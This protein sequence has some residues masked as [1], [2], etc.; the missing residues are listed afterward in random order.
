MLGSGCFL[1]LHARSQPKLFL[2]ATSSSV[3]KICRVDKAYGSALGNEEIF[4]LCDK[5]QKGNQ[6]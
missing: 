1:R 2:E 3:L 5:V 4:L 6:L